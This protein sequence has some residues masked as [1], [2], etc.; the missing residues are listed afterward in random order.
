MTIAI[1]LCCIMAG[2]GAWRSVQVYN[3]VDTI[4][5]LE[6]TRSLQAV[7]MHTRLE[8]MHQK[9]ALLEKVIG[10]CR[11]S[12]THLYGQ[13]QLCVHHYNQ[14]IATTSAGNDGSEGNR[15]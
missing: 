1:L 2:V 4:R 10:E 3:M 15:G 9:D 7:T 13:I 8:Q 11:E 12:L 6:A 5:M 14:C